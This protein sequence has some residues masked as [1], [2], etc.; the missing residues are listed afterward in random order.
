MIHLKIDLFR[1]LDFDSFVDDGVE[2][3][4][5]YVQL[6]RP[7]NF[8]LLNDAEK[9]VLQNYLTLQKIMVAF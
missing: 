3:V 7:Q 8:D 4:V 2:V 1:I 6:G 9:I 5:H